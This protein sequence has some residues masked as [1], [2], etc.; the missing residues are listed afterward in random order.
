MRGEG[1]VKMKMMVMVML[2]VMVALASKTQQHDLAHMFCTRC[3]GAR[4]V[5]LQESLT[6]A[7]AISAS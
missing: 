6:R 5:A 7:S 1:D 4:V 3:S 2:T